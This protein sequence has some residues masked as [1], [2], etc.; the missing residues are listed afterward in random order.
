MKA[1]KATTAKGSK[2]AAAERKVERARDRWLAGVGSR[3]DYDI[4][5]LELR[6][7]RRGRD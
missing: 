1:T 7:A 5:K 4:A 6:V 3:R 2:L